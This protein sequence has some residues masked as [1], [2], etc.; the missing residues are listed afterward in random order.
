M[1]VKYKNQTV[2][3]VKLILAHNTYVSKPILVQVKIEYKKN[4]EIVS[5]YID[6]DQVEFI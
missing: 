2:K 4:G 5:D 6:A 3:V 1:K